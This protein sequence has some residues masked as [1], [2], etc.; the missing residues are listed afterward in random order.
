MNPPPQDDNLTKWRMILGQLA[1]P[2]QQVSLDGHL[3]GI[4]QTLAALYDADRK[5]GLG[6]S[7]P[8]VNRWLGDIRR[9]F[10]T[11]VVQLMQQDALERLKLDR[12]LLEPELLSTVTPN[13]SLVGTLLSLKKVLPTQTKATAREVVQRVVEDL[14]RRLRQP[15]LE[16]I[17]GALSR[18]VRNRRPKLK[19]IDWHATIRRNLKH[20]QPTHQTIVPHD[21][22]GHG[23]KGQSLKQVVLLVDQSGSMAS[24][25][26]YASVVAAVMASVRAIKTHLVVFDTEVVDLTPVLEDPVEVLFGTQLGGGTDIHKAVVYGS[27]LIT[28]PSD[29]IVVLISDLYEG[30]NRIQLLQRI[31]RLQQDG[32]QLITLLALNDEGKP[33]YDKELATQMQT[34]GVTAFACNPDL[35]PSLMAAAINKDSIDEWR[36]RHNIAA[37]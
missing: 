13:V 10:P 33:S 24:S 9:Y 34:L 18:S 30:G 16:A 15:M 3:K 7:N 14:Q 12:M 25:V 8:N 23:K 32:V 28:S 29:A 17:K 27:Q 37:A 21:L 22:I 36:H 31:Q 6:G 11:D 19:E 4:D 2:D 5:G 26:V 1:D 20:Y 35:F